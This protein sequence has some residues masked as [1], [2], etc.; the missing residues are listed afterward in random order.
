MLKIGWDVVSEIL[1]KGN[2]YYF[3]VIK[4]FSASCYVINVN[5]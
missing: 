3:L 4:L 2:C 5:N 1:S